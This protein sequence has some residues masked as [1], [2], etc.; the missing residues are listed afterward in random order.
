MPRVRRFFYTGPK[1]SDVAHICY[2]RYH[3]EG[4]KTACGRVTV[5]GWYWWHKA[6]RFFRLCRQCEVAS[7]R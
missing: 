3:S 4:N 2:A 1:R 5:K 6:S 7:G